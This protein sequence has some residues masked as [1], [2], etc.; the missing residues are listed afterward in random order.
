MRK[1]DANGGALKSN[2]SMSNGSI[3]G[4]PYSTT[5]SHYVQNFRKVMGR[6]HEA[7]EY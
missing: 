5:K 2:M 1:E 4:K 6:N 3:R 7:V